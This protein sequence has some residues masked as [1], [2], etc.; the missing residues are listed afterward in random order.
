MKLL[1]NRIGAF[2][3]VLLA[4]HVLLIIVIPVGL[5]LMHFMTIISSLFFKITGI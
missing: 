1:L 2:I 4:I 5:W 3:F